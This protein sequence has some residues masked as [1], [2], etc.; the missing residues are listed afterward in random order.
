M[1]G[2]VLDVEARFESESET[3]VDEIY[4][5]LEGVER[6]RVPRGK[7]QLSR[8]HWHLRLRADHPP[9]TFTKGTHTYH[10]RF[11]LPPELPPRYSGA[12][13][14]ADYTL[15]VR[16]S[17]PWWPDAVGRYEVPIGMRTGVVSPSPG[18]FVSRAGGPI[19]GEIYVELSL[20]STVV[21]P[22]GEL[23]GTVAFTHAGRQRGLRVSLVAYEHVFSNADFWAGGNVDEVHEARRWSYE[24]GN[25]AV[26]EDGVPLP[27]RFAIAPG[28]VPSYSGAIT[29]LTWAVEVS[30]QGLILSRP[31]L[32]APIT[33][34]PPF[35]LAR[36]QS[37]FVPAVGRQRRTESLK[38]VAERLRL[39]YDDLQD[40]VRG[41]VG[42]VSFHA[43]METQTDGAQVTVARLSWPSLGMRLKLAPSGWTDAFNTRDISVG[44]P[45][46]DERFC[47]ESRVEDQARALFDPELCKL[48]L[49]FDEA[50]MDDH[51]AALVTRMALMDEEPLTGFVARAQHTA[52][53]LERAFT[54]V[55]P[56]PE[57]LAHVEAWRSYAERLGGRFEP[58]RG[59]IVDGTLGLERVDIATVWSASGEL[60][61]TELRVPLGSAIDPATISQAAR[62]LAA[63]LEAEPGQ[64]LAISG[65]SITLT[66]SSLVP[67]PASLEP[68]LEGL[69]R[70]AHTVLGRGGAGPFR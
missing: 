11:Q 13:A 21:E 70:L 53:A 20:A 62:A 34:V 6:L 67:D 3:P 64:K 63:S 49:T 16:A 19:G 61:G 59:A 37:A 58:G 12:H 50:R 7:S 68:L 31:L 33:I 57:L 2:S 55:P 27:F 54:R 36:T 51:G 26:P 8:E 69:V 14:W 48:L 46:F 30:V 38:R 9:A 56:P 44:Q 5:L 39:A 45:H 41:A 1:P 10:A 24:P 23:Y 18:V 29:E 35:G 43:H 28:A 66:V 65:D 60:F 4:F 25:G 32:R 17:I 52:A 15:E 22:G 40:G 47:L 42:Q